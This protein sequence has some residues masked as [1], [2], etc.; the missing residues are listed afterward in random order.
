MPALTVIEH[1]HVL[2]QTGLRLFASEVVAMHDEFGLQGVKKAFHR[3]IVPT[4]SFAAHALAN[5]VLIKQRPIVRRR[6]ERSAIGMQD[7][8][9]GAALSDE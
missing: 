1:L 9:R 5:G 4:I 3:R 7:F 8:W 2:E 6:V